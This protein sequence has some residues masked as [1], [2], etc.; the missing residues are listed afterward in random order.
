MN[1]PLL[2]S[3]C[4]AAWRP[5]YPFCTKAPFC[6]MFG[7]LI[8]EQPPFITWL[9]NMHFPWNIS[10]TCLPFLDRMGEGTLL[11]VCDCIYPPRTSLLSL[12]HESKQRLFVRPKISKVILRSKFHWSSSQFW[13]T[14]SPWGTCG[15]E[16]S[17]ITERL[18]SVRAG[19]CSPSH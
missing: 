13:D 12:M 16:V 8:I 3:K 10:S 5:F 19:R 14:F 11:F 6:D 4:V 18:T 2:L 15:R 7:L 17:G 1:A 9:S